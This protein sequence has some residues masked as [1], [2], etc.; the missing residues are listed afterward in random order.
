ML[1]SQCTEQLIPG[2]WTNSWQC[3][4]C[5]CSPSLPYSLSLLFCQQALCVLRIYRDHISSSSLTT[6]TVETQ[7]P[8]WHL[9]NGANKFTRF[10]SF[11][12]VGNCYYYSLLMSSIKEHH[13]SKRLYWFSKADTRQQLTMSSLKQKWFKLGHKQNHF[14][15]I[16]SCAC[17]LCLLCFTFRY[18]AVPFPIPNIIKDN[19]PK[20]IASLRDNPSW[21]KRGTGWMYKTL[22]NIKIS[23]L[24][25]DCFPLCTVVPML[26]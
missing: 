20:H 25:G 21:Q 6:A 1:T 23:I 8:M 12:H 14:A 22:V 18:Q 15:L 9:A 24:F 17:T 4:C 13:Q 3:Y 2:F 11:Q 19:S 16:K 7:P 26:E 5:I 10:F